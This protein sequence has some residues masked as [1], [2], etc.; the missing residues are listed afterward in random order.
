MY[1]RDVLYLLSE[2][3]P[4]WLTVYNIRDMLNIPES[5]VRSALKQIY[6]EKLVTRAKLGNINIYCRFYPNYSKFI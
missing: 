3:Y 5:S 6:E 4:Y 2:K 1:Y